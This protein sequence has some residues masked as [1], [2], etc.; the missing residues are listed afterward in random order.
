MAVADVAPLLQLAEEEPLVPPRQRV[1]PDDTVKVPLPEPGPTGWLTRF[2]TPAV[3]VRA[4]LAALL[5][6]TT[7]PSLMTVAPALIVRMW[8]VVAAER[9]V[10]V[11]EAEVIVILE[12]P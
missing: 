5:I 12:V 4:A 7:S 6:V 3:T 9:R 2:K 11:S 1:A 10:G 8:N